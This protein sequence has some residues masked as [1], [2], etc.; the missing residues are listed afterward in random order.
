VLQRRYQESLFARESYSKGG[1]SLYEGRHRSPSADR[2]PIHTIKALN[3]RQRTPPRLHVLPS[4]FALFVKADSAMLVHAL[5]ASEAG[6]AKRAA[7][8]RIRF[9]LMGLF[10]RRA[11]LTR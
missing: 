1:V 3:N 6:R 9:A 7:V 4:D 2:S 10:G 11:A 5:D 8:D